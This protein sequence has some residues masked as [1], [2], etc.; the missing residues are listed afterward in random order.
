MKENVESKKTELLKQY[1]HEELD[2]LLLNESIN[3]SL[4]LALL[5]TL[6]GGSNVCTVNAVTS[7]AMTLASD[8]KLEF[9]SYKVPN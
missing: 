1:S 3:S 9:E 7:I 2:K 6:N 4:I 8:A 5:K